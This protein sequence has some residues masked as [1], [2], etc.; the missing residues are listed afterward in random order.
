MLQLTIVGPANGSIAVANTP[1]VF[2]ART[3]PPQLAAKINWTVTNHPEAH[4]IGAT[5]A[6][7]FAAT[8]V[9]QVVAGLPAAGLVCDAIVYIFKTPSDGSTAADIAQAEPPPPGARGAEA[10]TAYG[11][12]ASGIGRAS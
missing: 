5:F 1:V 10:F 9:E 11:P 8:G 4:G 12:H 7:S 3:D 2:T 6:H